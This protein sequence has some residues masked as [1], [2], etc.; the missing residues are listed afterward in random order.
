MSLELALKLVHVF[1]AFWL[2]GGLFA[3][4]ATLARAEHADDIRTV[5]DLTALAGRFDV[6]VRPA[7]FVVLV[8]GLL[9]AWAQGQPLFG[10]GAGWVTL[11]L[12]LFFSVA[13]LIVF[14]FLPAGRRFDSELAAARERGSVTTELQSAFRNP[15]V[16][17]AHVYEVVNLGV[18]IYLMI[19]KP[20]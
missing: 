11:S 16:R 10:E 20:F 1:A 7:S 15:A 5:S 19:A 9:T 14:V 13:P 17:A 6:T 18:I 4:W 3:R 12:I 2:V 8:A